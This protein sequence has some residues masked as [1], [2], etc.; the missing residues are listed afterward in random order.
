VLPEDFRSQHRHLLDAA[1]LDQ[2]TFFSYFRISP[3]GRL[4]FGGGPVSRPTD[5]P[6]ADLR[7]SQ[8]AWQR[9]RREMVQLFPAL[10][11][12]SLVASWS[13]TTGVAPNRLPVVGPVPGQPDVYFAGAWC[14]HGVSLSVANGA[15]VA[16]D[17]A[18]DR[19]LDRLPW[20][21]GGTGLPP[22]G[23][24]QAPAVRAYLRATDVLDRLGARI[25]GGG[26]DHS[27]AHEPALGTKEIR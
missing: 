20:H 2:R 18:G 17:L 5:V 14:G 9:L 25:G 10:T 4:L 22:T 11:E 12:V 24:L 8:I 21:R 27:G 6:A 3:Q 13:G 15:W 16:A 7:G 26:A 1:V 23:P 19:T